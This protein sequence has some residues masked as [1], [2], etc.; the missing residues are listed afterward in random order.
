V[1]LEAVETSYYRCIKCDKGY[2][3]DDTR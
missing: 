3:L 1:E 2:V